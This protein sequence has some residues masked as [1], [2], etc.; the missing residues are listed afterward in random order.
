MITLEL[1]QQ[2]TKQI[3]TS[4]RF[5]SD[6]AQIQ[7]TLKELLEYEEYCIW[8]ASWNVFE[9]SLFLRQATLRKLLSLSTQI[10]V[11]GRFFQTVSSYRLRKLLE[12]E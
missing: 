3:D 5:Y 4:G 6:S 1:Y 12:Y 9:L 7:V 2:W 8:W 10:N 11:R